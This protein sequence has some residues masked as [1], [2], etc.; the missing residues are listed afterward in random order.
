MQGAREK[1]G[2][3]GVHLGEHPCPSCGRSSDPGRW[4]EP[5]A[6][7]AQAQ[8]PRCSPPTPP[9]P[10]PPR[11]HPSMSPGEVG[12]PAGLSR[13]DPHCKG[14]RGIHSASVPG[15]E[16]QRLGRSLSPSRWQASWGR[17]VVDVT[18]GRWQR[19]TGEEMDLG[20]DPRIQRLCLL[21]PVP[22]DPLLT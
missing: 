8:G 19:K 16:R 21:R 22:E 2:Q 7:T 13:V 5:R 6:E 14:S 15:G 4:T 12:R 18:R 1:Q 20:P 11:M 17:G 10:V 9:L 3:V